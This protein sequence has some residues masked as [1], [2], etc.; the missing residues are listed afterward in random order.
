MK[1]TNQTKLASLSL[2]LYIC[3]DN[4]NLAEAIYR[5]KLAATTVSNKDTMIEMCE[6]HYTADD[7]I[8]EVDL[9]CVSSISD[10]TCYDCIHQLYHMLRQ[11]IPDAVDYF[12][13]HNNRSIKYMHQIWDDKH[14]DNQTN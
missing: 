9:S 2:Q 11:W 14:N 10:Q 8:L 6:V 3:L 1:K 13:L 12:L 4:S 5:T 7:C